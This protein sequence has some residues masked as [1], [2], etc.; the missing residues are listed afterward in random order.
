L[1]ARKFEEKKWYIPASFADA[2]DFLDAKAV[3]VK[4]II[5]SPVCPV[6]TEATLHSEGECPGK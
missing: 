2:L 3:I 1:L 6:E 5:G 4:S